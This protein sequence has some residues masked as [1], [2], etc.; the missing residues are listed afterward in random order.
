MP[1]PPIP[2]LVLQTLA[3]ALHSMLENTPHSRASTPPSVFVSISSRPLG[4]TDV[5][6]FSPPDALKRASMS[7]SQNHAP[8]ALF[9]SPRRLKA[10]ICSLKRIHTQA[11][12]FRPSNVQLEYTPQ[13]CSV[14][15]IHTQAMYF[16]PL[17]VQLEFTPHKRSL[18]PIHTQAAYFRPS[19]VQLE[20]TP[21]KYSLRPI[22]T[23]AVYF[24]PLQIWHG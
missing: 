12:Y 23:Q 10:H 5:I 14:R 18:R 21:Q 3:R 4:W 24:R 11:M 2:L 13:K 9:H 7:L 22:H 15:P 1:L 8:E 19:N 6:S 16:R 20:Y 17:N